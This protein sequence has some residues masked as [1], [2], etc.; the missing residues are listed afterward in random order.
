M[1]SKLQLRDTIREQ[2]KSFSKEQ[3]QEWSNQVVQRIKANPLYVAAQSVMLYN[4]LPD[5][6]NLS[7]LWDDEKQKWWLPLVT[8]VSTMEARTYTRK[9]KL[10]PGSFGIGEPG[11]DTIK[12]KAGEID[13]I[14]I[15]GMAFDRS[16]NRLGRGKGYYDRF[17]KEQGFAYRLGVCFPFQLLDTIPIESND[18]CMNQIITPQEDITL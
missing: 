9:D 16:G 17:L 2:K 13:L 7:E 15:P 8:G 10:I 12:A 3:L 11:K 14:I 4:A 6:V 18:V 5:E 1:L